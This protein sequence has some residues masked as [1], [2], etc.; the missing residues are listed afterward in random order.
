VTSAET[1]D[2][3]ADVLAR[4]VVRK[5]IR[6]PSEKIDE[7]QQDIASVSTRFEPTETLTLSDDPDDNRVL[8]AAVAA[9]ADY[10]VT[11]D[12]G[13]L[14]LAEVRGTRIRTPARFLVEL[15][16]LE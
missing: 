5:F 15:A 7:L 4:P 1:L 12:A 3:L 2:E 13:L 6:V 16:T 10:I 9:E 11:G 14:R 8:E